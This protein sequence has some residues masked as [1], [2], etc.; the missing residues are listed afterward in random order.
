MRRSLLNKLYWIVNAW[1][2]VLF[3]SYCIILNYI[4]SLLFV[5]LAGATLL[6]T[7][8]IFNLLYYVRHSKFSSK[9]VSTR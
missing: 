9:V 7:L 2:V 8:L 3:V 6:L 5:C 1:I 4:N